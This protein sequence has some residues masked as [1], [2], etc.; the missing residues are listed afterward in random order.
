MSHIDLAA[1]LREA[2]QT[3]GQSQNALAKKAEISQPVLSDFLAEKKDMYLETA[4]KLCRVLPHNPFGG[5]M[6]WRMNNQTHVAVVLAPNI[7]RERFC[8]LTQA[9]QNSWVFRDYITGLELKCAPPPNA[10]TSTLSL[11]QI[12]AEVTDWGPVPYHDVDDAAAWRSYLQMLTTGFTGKRRCDQRPGSS[13]FG[14]WQP[15]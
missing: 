14:A 4:N 11:N 6:P 10:S 15:I 12:L 13:R 3:C 7:S 8:L 5:F 2:I 1:S 9:G